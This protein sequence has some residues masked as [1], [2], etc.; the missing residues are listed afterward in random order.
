[1]KIID[2][3]KTQ[4]FEEG[5]ALYAKRGTW[6]KPVECWGIEIP[7]SYNPGTFLL[8]I[9]V[10]AVGSYFFVKDNEE[11]PESAARNCYSEEYFALK[12][13]AG[14]SGMFYNPATLSTILRASDSVR[15]NDSRIG[16]EI[17]RESCCARVGHHF[18]ILERGDVIDHRRGSQ[19]NSVDYSVVI[20]NV[21]V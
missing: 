8:S 3:T 20:G 6:G 18:V 17:V 19:S 5:S 10:D 9:S 21:F 2:L 13:K 16:Y 4:S 1:M 14:L 7:S 12:R 11:I 15:Q